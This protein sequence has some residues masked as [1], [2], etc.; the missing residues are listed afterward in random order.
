MSALKKMHVNYLQKVPYPQITL[1]PFGYT[2]EMAA[3]IEEGRERVH[4]KE[5][6]DEDYRDIE[7]AG[8]SKPWER[9][10]W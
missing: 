8:C 9:C 5:W 7:D 4:G 1:Y 2:P 3:T 10:D 6:S